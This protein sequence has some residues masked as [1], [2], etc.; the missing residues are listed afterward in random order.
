MLVTVLFFGASKVQKS[1]LLLKTFISI[2]RDLLGSLPKPSVTL[3]KRDIEFPPPQN[4]LTFNVPITFR[5]A[6]RREE[7]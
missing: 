7:A 4:A 1:G 6:Q 5:T 2:Y 3:A